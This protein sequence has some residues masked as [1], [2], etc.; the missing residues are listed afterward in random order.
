ME[1]MKLVDSYALVSSL[2][3]F[4]S[5]CFWKILEKSSGDSSNS[6]SIRKRGEAT[7][8]TS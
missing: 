4:E 6:S 8:G 1:L 2:I 5:I 3:V 7:G